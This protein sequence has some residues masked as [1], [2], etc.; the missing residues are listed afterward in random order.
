VLPRNHQIHVADYDTG[1]L[2][3]SP[4]SSCAQRCCAA[5]TPDISLNHSRKCTPRE[6][7]EESW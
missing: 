3:A 5:T 4:P 2:V 6:M 1:H 7:T